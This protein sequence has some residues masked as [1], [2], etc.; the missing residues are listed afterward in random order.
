MAYI[1]NNRFFD[2]QIHRQVRRVLINTFDEVFIVNLHGD[3]R[4]A[5][6]CPDGSSDENIFQIQQG[7]GISLFIKKPHNKIRGTNQQNHQCIVHYTDL[8]GTK[9]VKYEI[10]QKKNLQ[11]L[12]WET[13]ELR[14]PMN[15]FLPQDFSSEDEFNNGF[16]VDELFLKKSPSDVA[17]R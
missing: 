8:W 15:Y 7:V 3:S 16:S 13:I 10:L 2:G 12:S 4:R 1:S 17:I 9:D 11:D 14:E 5:E 6:T